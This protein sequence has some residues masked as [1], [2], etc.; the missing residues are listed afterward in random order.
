MPRTCVQHLS[1][2]SDFSKTAKWI[3][4]KL[5]IQMAVR[6]VWNRKRVVQTPEICRAVRLG[7]SC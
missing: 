7:G 2:I 3:S 1:F 4:T 6:M 5:S